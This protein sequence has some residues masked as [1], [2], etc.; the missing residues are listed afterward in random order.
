MNTS[1]SPG[2]LKVGIFTPYVGLTLN[3]TIHA[4]AACAVSVEIKV[5]NDTI[6]VRTAAAYDMDGTDDSP[7]VPESKG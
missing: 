7:E 4:G 2:D 6:G 5:G 1:I 3:P